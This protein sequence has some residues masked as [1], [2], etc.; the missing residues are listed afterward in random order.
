MN[1]GRWLGLAL[2]VLPLVLSRAPSERTGHTEL[3]IALALVI[4]AAEVAGT[5]RGD[6]TWG[7]MQLLA[8]FGLVLV[9]PSPTAMSQI[10]PWMAGISVLLFV[11]FFSGARETPMPWSGSR[12]GGL[13]FAQLARWVPL[14]TAIA[15]CVLVP[16]TFGRL[17]P[18]GVSRSW[19]IAEVLAVAV[20]TLWVA[21]LPLLLSGLSR[22]VAP[23]RVPGHAPAV[24]TANIE[25]ATP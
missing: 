5:P 11:G 12:P 25:G 8:L 19:E 6:R 10:P 4:L 22:L 2:L 15:A 24:D 7:S 13:S 16:L 17:F 3:V 23:R 21:G 9:P 14:V 20:A 18:P 1:V